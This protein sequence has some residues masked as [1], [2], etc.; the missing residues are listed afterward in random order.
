VGL[1]VSED[2]LLEARRNLS[3]SAPEKLDALERLFGAVHFEIVNPARRSVLG[4]AN[5]VAVKDAAIVA[6]ARKAKV[7]ALVTFDEKRLL[8]NVTLA[9]YLRAPVIRPQPAVEMVRRPA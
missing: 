6:A 8:R 7:S 9:S 3:Y 4:A 2:V 5:H 1:V